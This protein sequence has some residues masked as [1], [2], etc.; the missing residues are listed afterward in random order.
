MSVKI[1]NVKSSVISGVVYDGRKHTLTVEFHSKKV[2]MYH[3]VPAKKFR[4][5]I[6]A[7]SAGVFYNENI[8]GQYDSTELEAA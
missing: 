7:E 1:V 5:L 6:A 4:D 8:K 3:G 2:Y